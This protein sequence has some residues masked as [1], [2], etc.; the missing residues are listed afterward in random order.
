MTR[1]IEHARRRLLRLWDLAITADLSGQK[2]IDLPMARNRGCTV[3]CAVYIDSVLTAF[4]KEL[5]TM[6]LQVP[7]EVIP[8]HAA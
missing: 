6:P 8:L 4:S 3:R 2:V 5:T 1:T 7:N